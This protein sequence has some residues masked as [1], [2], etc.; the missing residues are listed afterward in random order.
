MLT[1]IYQLI[2]LYL[3]LLVAYDVFK[4]KSFM[5]KITAALVMIPFVLRLL[6]IK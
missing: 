2:L 4:E 3:I 5:M 6:M 1:F